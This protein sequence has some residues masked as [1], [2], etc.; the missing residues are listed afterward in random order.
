MSTLEARA[1]LAAGHEVVAA[2]GHGRAQAVFLVPKEEEAEAK[3]MSR[4]MLCSLPSRASTD[5]PWAPRALG[6]APRGHCVAGPADARPLTQTAEFDHAIS[7]FRPRDGGSRAFPVSIRAYATAAGFSS[8]YNDIARRLRLARQLTSQIVQLVNT[9]SPRKLTEVAPEEPEQAARRVTVLLLNRSHQDAHELRQRLVSREMCVEQ[10]TALLAEFDDLVRAHLNARKTR[11]ECFLTALGLDELEHVAQFLPISAAASLAQTNRFFSKCKQ[12]QDLLPKPKIRDLEG[13]LYHFKLNQNRFVCSRRR[14]QIFVD[15]VARR[16]RKHGP[17]E[18]VD[19]KPA[20]RPG[21]AEDF[22]RAPERLDLR[23]PGHTAHGFALELPQRRR[24][25]KCEG[26]QTDV[27]PRFEDMRIPSNMYFE[28]PPLYTV[29]LLFA[30][31]FEPVQSPGNPRGIEASRQLETDRFFFCQSVNPVVRTKPNEPP[32]RASSYTPFFLGKPLNAACFSELPAT[33]AFFARVLSSDAGGRQMIIRLE[34]EA[35]LQPRRQVQC[36]A[37][38]VRW[39]VDSPA[40]TVVSRLDHVSASAGAV[41]RTLC[42]KRPREPA[43]EEP[44]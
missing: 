11:G 5:A 27:D 40:F 18:R 36:G 21:P 35:K 13:Y 9:H 10:A 7:C 38:R 28:N 3:A 17:L 22:T 37:R 25:L 34:A 41:P 12:V 26:P 14:V 39:T 33:A 2:A 29:S 43:A 24:W 6:G 31:N 32:V 8:F 23:G 42:P 44:C 16:L 30:D 19:G 15:F 1:V 20:T 4:L